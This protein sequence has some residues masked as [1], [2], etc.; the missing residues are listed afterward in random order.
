MIKAVEHKKTE[1]ERKY[2]G[3]LQDKE[4]GH[5]RKEKM[6]ECRRKKRQM[7]KK[8]MMPLSWQKD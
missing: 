6:E 7:V 3:S 1:E 4:V 5:E 8:E 2:G